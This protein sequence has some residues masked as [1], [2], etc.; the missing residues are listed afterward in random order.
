MLPAAHRIAMRG[1]FFFV[2]AALAWMHVPRADAQTPGKPAT[3]KPVDIQVR[4]SQDAVH[5]HSSILAALML[6]IRPGWHVNSAQ[7]SDSSLIGTLVEPDR[8]PG[9]RIAEIRYPA[10]I[11]KKLTFAEEPLSVYEGTAI[12]VMKIEVGDSLRLGDHLLRAAVTY[13][14]CNDR[15]CLPPATVY[16][17]VPLRVVAD[18]DPVSFTNTELFKGLR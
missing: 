9:V 15:M 18:A 8:L 10:G 7:P 3:A 12:V 5:R 2:T 17:D 13:Q 16:A 11:E 4:V 6:S 1:I 14:A